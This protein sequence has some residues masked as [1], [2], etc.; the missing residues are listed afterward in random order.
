ML[1][2]WGSQD[3]MVPPSLAPVFAALNPQ[4]KYI[5]LEQVGHCPHDECPEKFNRILLDWLKEN[6]AQN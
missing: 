2:I 1:F 4:I 3:K 5:E 6:F